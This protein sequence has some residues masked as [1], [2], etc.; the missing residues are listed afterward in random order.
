[1][2]FNKLFAAL[3]PAYAKAPAGR[4]VTKALTSLCLS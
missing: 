3:K 1:M 4:A 2:F